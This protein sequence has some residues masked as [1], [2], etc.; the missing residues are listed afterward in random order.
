MLLV[1]F[2]DTISENLVHKGQLMIIEKE[3]LRHQ[4]LERIPN[5][6]LDTTKA[7]DAFEKILESTSG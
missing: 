7:V 1:P 3:N 2:D 4:F 6:K 5:I